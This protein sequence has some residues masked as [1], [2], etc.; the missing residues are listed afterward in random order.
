MKTPGI[1]G[2]LFVIILQVL[3]AFSAQAE[4]KFTKEYHRDFNVTPNMLFQLINKFGDVQIENWDKNMV[5][6]NVVITV[7]TS[8]KDKA[9]A[10]FE[11]IVINF[12]QIDTMIS[13]ITNIREHIKNGK[14]SIDYTIKMPKNQRMDLQNSYGDVFIN[15]LTG[16]SNITVKYGNFQ[17][18]K[19]NFGDSK[20][21]TYLYLAYS[22][23]NIENCDWLKIKLDFSK[24][25]IES[26]EALIIKSKYSKLQIEKCN[27]IVA[28]SRFDDPFDI[29]QVNNFVCTGEYSNYNIGKINNKLDIDLKYSNIDVDEV[30]NN[31]ND[32]T[33]G[34]KY[35]HANI[36][37]SDNASYA[38]EADAD[39]GSVDIPDCEIIKKIVDKT[40]SKITAVVGSSKSP[41]AKVKISTK[42]GNVELN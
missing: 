15:E 9:N 3:L 40:E 2:T 22:N 23:G 19:L 1:K 24:L 7:E 11:K 14:I 8:S 25:D 34:L 26:A 35:G 20:P 30:S 4:D 27:S 33:V 17:A 38:L 29:E 16:K 31:F 41:K 5:S 32:I 28:D 37:F 12:S 13:A 6:V 10:I 21:R 42:F 18:N 39:Y 36:N